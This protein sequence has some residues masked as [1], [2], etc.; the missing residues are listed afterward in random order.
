M[1]GIGFLCRDAKEW[2]VESGDILL[3]KMRTTTVE[4]IEFIGGRMIICVGIESIRWYFG[5]SS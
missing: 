4:R 2:C 5:E 1:H 3:H